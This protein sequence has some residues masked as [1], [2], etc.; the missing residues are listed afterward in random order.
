MVKI[1]LQ[2]VGKRNRPHY[3]LV[4]V[5]S[6]E[7]VSGK[8]LGIVGSYDPLKKEIQINLPEVQKWQSLGA[9]LTPRA[10]ALIKI[11]TKSTQVVKS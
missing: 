8:V 3:R 4:V 6:R 2:R 9:R 1:R 5:D 10:R 11:Y 7:A